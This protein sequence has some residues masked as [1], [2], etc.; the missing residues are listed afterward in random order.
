MQMKVF[1]GWGKEKRND[2]RKERAAEEI[3][4]KWNARKKQREGEKEDNRRELEKSQ[5]SQRQRTLVGLEK[6]KC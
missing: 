6:E 5:H 2:K 1:R 4:K 3:K